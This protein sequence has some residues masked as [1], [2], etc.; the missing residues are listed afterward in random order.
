[1]DSATAP[2]AP[3]RLGHA[4]V[5]Q[6]ALRYLEALGTWR[7]ERKAELD[8][9]D[10]AALGAVDA[11]AYT[12]DLLLSMALWK[13]VADRL[14]LLVA[15]WDSGR[16]GPTELERLSTLVWG[17]LDATT[18]HARGVGRCR[19]RRSRAFSPGRL[20]ARG[21]PALRRTRRLVARPAGHRP[22]GGRPP[23]TAAC[24]ARLRGTGPRPRRPRAG[25]GTRGGFGDPRPARRPCR[26]RPGQDPA[27]RRRRRPAGPLG[28]RRR[29]RR[30]RPHRRRLEPARRRPRRGDGADPACRA[31]GPRRCPAR[32]RRPMRGPGRP[33][34]PAGGAR[35]VGARAR[36]HRSRCRGRLPG[37]ARRR[38]P[39]DDGG[40]GRLRLGA[41]R[42][43][44]AQGHP[45]GV[46]RQGCGAPRLTRLAG[47]GLLAADLA[48]LQRRASDALDREPADLVRGRAL[49]AAYRAYLASA[50]PDRARPNGGGAS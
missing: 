7:D 22:V 9:L 46:R 25:P 21:L 48:E 47:S 28:A 23:G 50:Q 8:V 26:R 20:A 32:P 16:V 36:A 45:G 37:A 31:R 40:A 14:D 43:G 44:R 17:R 11:A 12:G 27:G 6:D 15:T 30:A 18:T 33:R 1:M 42:T 24:A 2:V 38:R 10:E 3:G 19:R 35:R 41:V 13:A 5:P 34:S 39:G 29:P 49:V 4:L